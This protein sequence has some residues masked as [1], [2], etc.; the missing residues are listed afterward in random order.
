MTLRWII[1][2]RKVVCSGPG[3]LHFIMH[4]TIGLTDEL[5]IL[6]VMPGFHHSVAVLP[7]PFRR[8]E[9]IRKLIGCPPTTERQKIWFDPIATERQL[10]RNGKWKRHNGFFFM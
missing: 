6:R 9:A 10:R 5:T 2:L 7:L 1:V 4:R 8:E 3:Q